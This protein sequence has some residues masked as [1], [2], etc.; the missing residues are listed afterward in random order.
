M[1]LK[2]LALAGLV[3]AMGGCLP[4]LPVRRLDAPAQVAV[5]YVADAERG[6][7]VASVPEG[8]KAKVVEALAKRNLVSSEVPF[9][10]LSADFESA[11][12]SKLRY[13]K[14]AAAA[15]GAPFVLLVETKASFF[16]QI[17]GRYRWTVYARLS[18]GKAGGDSVVD[19]F[20]LPAM[21]DFDHEHEAEAL[22]MAAPVIAE[23]AGAVFDSF[24]AA[25]ATA[26]APAPVPA[27]VPAPEAAPAL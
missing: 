8:L 10:K 21:L 20:N 9:E 2:R 19:E 25:R 17:S 1:V 15:G 3:L 12:D 27:P 22:A 7:G 26:S 13:Q 18:A 23:R 11:R 6:V 4:R 14:V 5:A 16:S 24:L